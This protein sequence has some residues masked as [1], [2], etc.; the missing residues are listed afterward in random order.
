[1]LML[2]V[3]GSIAGLMHG[4][5]LK[6]LGHNVR[7]LERSQSDL[8][9][10]QGAGVTAME[11]VLQFLSKHDLSKQP[12]YVASAQIQFLDR[13]ANIVKIW[14]VPLSMTSWNTLYYR[15]RANFDGLPSDYVPQTGDLRGE[16]DGKVK[17]EH[18]VMV[19]DLQCNDEVVTVSFEELNGQTGSLQADLVIAADGPSSTIRKILSPGTS[20]KYVGYVAWRGTVLECDVSESTKKVFNQ[21]LTYFIHKG[22]TI[23]L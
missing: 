2:Q 14:K 9:H 15:L 4:L 16:R 1:M 23:L 8:L 10:D 7:I 5:V 17:Y 3:G 12:N 20:R 21:N 19:T 6:R 18:G 22:A 13:A 11:N